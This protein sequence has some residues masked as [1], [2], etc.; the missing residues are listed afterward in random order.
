VTKSDSYSE[1]RGTEKGD[2]WPSLTCIQ[3]VTKLG[4]GGCW[5]R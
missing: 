3:N 1:L 2:K 5:A 4:R